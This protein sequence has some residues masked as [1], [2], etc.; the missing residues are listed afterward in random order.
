[1]VE[2]SALVFGAIKIAGAVYLVLLGVKAL[3]SSRPAIGSGTGTAGPATARG[4]RRQVWEG[5]TVGVTNPKSIVF[6]TAV[7]PQFVDRDAGRVV[8][9]M[10]LLGLAGAV[11]QM[12]SDSVWGMAAS[13]A[14]A[15]MGRSPR[16]TA[17][18]GRAGGMAM[19]GLGLSV[20]VTGRA[21]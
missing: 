20:A 6:L 1:M 4:G 8:G 14:R 17:L 19:I 15:W 16:R 21:D 12:S 9:Q 10:L 18:L 7:L 2:Q 13:A 5:F 3:R 11:L